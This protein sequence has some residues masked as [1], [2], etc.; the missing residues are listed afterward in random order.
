M[1]DIEINYLKNKLLNNVEK[2]NN[3]L[4]LHKELGF[5]DSVKESTSEL[6]SYDNH[7]ADLG[8][9]TYEMDKQFALTRHS[10][11]QI[12]EIEAALE[13]IADGSYGICQF[14]GRDICFERLDALP[15]ARLCIEC[16]EQRKIEIED[17]ENDRPI[18]ED[19]LEP[20]FT[21]TFDEDDRAF[22]DG[23]DAIQDIQKY[24]SSSGPQDISINNLV[25]Y[26]NTF[27]ESQEDQGYVEDVES[28]SNE[29]YR[30]QLPDS[31]GNS[32]DGYVERDKDIK[33]NYF[34]ELEHEE[35]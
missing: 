34:G 11:R 8:S 32:V 12:A 31:H 30:Q 14:C 1:K 23:E 20:A 2:Q 6:S 25:D 5:Q 4:S 7:P 22:Y 35:E 13:R 28:I 21:R 10:T 3:A 24:G 33:I 17:L 27:Y 26:Q 15:E 29:T 9:E 19:I 18:E 16:E